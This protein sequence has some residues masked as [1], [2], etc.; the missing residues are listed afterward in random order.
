MLHG[1]VS[2][3][4]SQIQANRGE[5]KRYQ[6][7]CE[8]LTQFKGDVSD[9]QEQIMYAISAKKRLMTELDSYS[10]ECKSAKVYSVG[11]NTT[12][13]SFG[14]TC[15]NTVFSNLISAIEAKLSEYRDEINAL[16]AQN[17]S[18]HSRIYSLQHQEQVLLDK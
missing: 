8:S 2:G 12:L 1:N 15:A 3:Y 9:T 5:I 11:M 10:A 17:S 13:D 14:E 4:L 7:L 18:L 6:D 16:E